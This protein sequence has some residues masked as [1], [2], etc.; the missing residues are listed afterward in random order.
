MKTAEEL[1]VYVQTLFTS[2]SDNV[3]VLKA[4]KELLYFWAAEVVFAGSH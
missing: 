2:R 1:Q 3:F 4:L